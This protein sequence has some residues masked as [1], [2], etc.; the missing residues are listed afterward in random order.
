[1]TIARRAAGCVLL[2]WIAPT[3][4]A[5]GERGATLSRSEWLSST[6]PRPPRAIPG[7]ADNGSKHQPIPRARPADAAVSGPDRNEPAHGP[8]GPIKFVPVAPLD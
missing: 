4:V 6:I 1:M 8:S 7:I 3:A 2:I 5:A